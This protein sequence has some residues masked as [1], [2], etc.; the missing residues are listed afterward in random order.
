MQQ[1]WAAASTLALSYRQLQLQDHS[2]VSYQDFCLRGTVAALGS[3]SRGARS[4]VC[5]RGR[6]GS[7]AAAAVRQ[8]QDR[9]LSSA[10]AG[11]GRTSPAEPGPLRQ[12]RE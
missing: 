1:G 8:A 3:R 2:Q 5:S 6:G 11:A 7:E 4:A 10:A 12:P 9:G